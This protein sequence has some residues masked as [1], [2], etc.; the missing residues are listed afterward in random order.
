MK[1]LALVALFLG[2]ALAPGFAQD[3]PR[4]DE[5]P[6][7]PEGM[8]PNLKDHLEKA[9]KLTPDQKAKVDAIQAR[10]KPAMEAKRE[11]AQTA[12]KAFMEAMKNVDAKAE[13]LKALHRAMADADFDALLEHRSQRQE[14]RAILT[15]E[16]REKA[17]WFEGRRE[18]RRMHRGGGPGEEG[19]R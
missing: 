7:R 9:L 12:R 16:Q 15:P 13:D 8:G 3:R 18:G 14:F 17:A 11:A 1:R 10:H 19:M 2:A 4:R 6:G 5:G